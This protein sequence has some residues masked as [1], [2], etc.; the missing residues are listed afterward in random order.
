[1]PSRSNP[2]RRL[3]SSLAA[4][5][6]LAGCG[7][8]S[9]EEQLLFRF[10]EASRLYDR[11]ALERVAAS[12]VALNP[13]TDGVVHDFSVGSV[14]ELGGRRIVRLTAEVRSPSGVELQAMEVEIARSGERWLITSLRRLPASQTGP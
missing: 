13:V 14:S 9:L 6:L 12:G 3:R 4:T 5:W 1:M 2:L 11:V 10:F 7:V 8:L